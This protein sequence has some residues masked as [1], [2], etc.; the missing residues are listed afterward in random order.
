MAISI[1]TVLLLLHQQTTSVGSLHTRTNAMDGTED[2]LLYEREDESD[3][4]VDLPDSD[5]DPY[6]AKTF[7]NDLYDELFA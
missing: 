4:E 6:Y 5:W 1:I 3:A 7:K 2:E